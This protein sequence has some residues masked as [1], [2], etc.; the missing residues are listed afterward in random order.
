MSKT[1]GEIQL[2]SIQNE[3]GSY[4][5]VWPRDGWSEWG[6]A[7]KKERIKF[8]NDEIGEWSMNSWSIS[9]CEEH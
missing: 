3:A 4:D 2:E 7:C 8:W 9:D 5:D 1:N 6:D